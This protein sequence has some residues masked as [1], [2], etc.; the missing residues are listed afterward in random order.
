MSDHLNNI[1]EWS[2]DNLI[3]NYKKTKEMLLG[4][5]N[6]NELGLLIVAIARDSTFKLLAIQVESNLKCQGLFSTVFFEIAEEMFK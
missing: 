2:R 3:V 6:G 5:V 1:I 4:E